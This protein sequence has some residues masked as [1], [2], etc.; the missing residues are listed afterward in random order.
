MSIIVEF[1][2]KSDDFELG[3][4]FSP[5]DPAATIE[6]E[7]LVFPS[8][9]MTLFVWITGPGH[10]MLEETVVGH[11]TVE[12]V[13]QIDAFEDRSLYAFDW[14]LEYDH[15]FR[16]F[17]E[18]EVQI[19]TAGATDGRW[20]F[21]LRFQAHN[22]LSAFQ[23]YIEAAQVLVD[24][25]SVRNLRDDDQ[26]T[27]YGLTETQRETLMLAVREGYYDIPREVST[28]ELGERFEISDQAVTERLRRAIATLV[29]NTLMIEGYY[30]S[31]R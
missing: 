8:R 22:E 20:T 11:P 6:L 10:S 3:R 7:S 9:G 5:V 28:S 14:T 2:L 27:F 1:E 18:N 25:A 17:R 26:T 24:V 19:L 13:E 29:R 23:A 12:A 21:I 16:Y 4:V 30:R 31:R 15:L